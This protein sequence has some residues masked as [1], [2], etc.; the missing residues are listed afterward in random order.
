MIYFIF[1]IFSYLFHSYLHEMS[2]LCAT[3]FLVGVDKYKIKPYPHKNQ[4][5]GFVW[6]SIKIKRINIAT[7]FQ[8]GLIF[9]SPRFANILF[10]L[11]I[12][13]VYLQGFELSIYFKIFLGGGMV[14][15][16]TGSLGVSES[17]DLKR[18]CK[19]WNL[20]PWQPRLVGCMLSIFFLIIL[21]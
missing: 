9:F 4:E 12:A 11:I 10:C 5:L 20:N 6:A 21:F 1:I 13:F 14:D 2:H 8:N 17:S 3:K 7:N 19:S 18:Y 15:L 16:L